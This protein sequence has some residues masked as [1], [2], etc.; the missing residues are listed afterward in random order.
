MVAEGVASV[1]S[2]AK[3]RLTRL[4]GQDVRVGGNVS[5]VSVASQRLAQSLARSFEDKKQAL[6]LFEPPDQLTWA[7]FGQPVAN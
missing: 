5:P 2:E 6:A 4:I 1:T 7:S 3:Q